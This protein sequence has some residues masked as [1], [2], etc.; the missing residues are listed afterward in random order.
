MP[1]TFNGTNGNDLNIMGFDYL[2]GGDGND[3]LGSDQPGLDIV[4]GGRGDDEVFVFS[5]QTA[6]GQLY[7]GDGSD[8]VV[9]NLLSDTLYGGEGSDVLLGSIPVTASAQPLPGE[10]SG[11]DLLFGGSGQDALYGFDGDDTLFGDSG[12]DDGSMVVVSLLPPGSR[13]ASS[14]ATAMT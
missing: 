4:E 8:L 9:G 3:T 6:R 14:A 10:A 12:E 2:Y 11:N 1:N 13:L 5:D 7:G